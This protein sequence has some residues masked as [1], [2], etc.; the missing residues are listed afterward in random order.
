MT[1]PKPM[2]TTLV[3]APFNDPHWIFEIKWDGYRALAVKSKGVKLL[4]RN[5]KSFNARF[6]KIVQELETIPES[7]VLDGEIVIFD[8]QGRSRFQLLQNAAR[9]KPGNLRTLLFNQTKADR[10][11]VPYYYVFDILS[12][13]GKDLR[14]LPL[15]ERK[16]IV[17]QFIKRGKYQFL[18]FS[19][20]KEKS[21]KSFFSYAQKK[22]LE[23]II[24]KRKESI[25]RPARTKDWLKIKTKMRQEVVIG[26][27]TAPRQSRKYFGSLLVGVYEKGKLVYAGHVG[28][29]FTE[30]LLASTYRQL[31]KLVRKTSPFVHEPRPNM[32]VTWVA[33][34]LVCEVS[35]AEWTQGGLMRQP[36]FEGMRVDKDPLDVEKETPK[37]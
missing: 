26:G 7:F 10:A 1:T 14:S 35:F 24:A 28:G 4:S 16:E 9:N 27:F 17:R 22:G 19:D 32:P 5:E 23:G 25:Y 6:P 20:Y 11:G 30:A 2:L 36:I 37:K 29:G 13:K 33:P 31:S 3:D 18:R 21:G 34:K 15:I 8:E 12:F